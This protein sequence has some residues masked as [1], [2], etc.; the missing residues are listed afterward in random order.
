MENVLRFRPWKGVLA[1][2]EEK[3]GGV[4]QVWPQQSVGHFPE[5]ME[6]SGFSLV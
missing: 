6:S 1:Q 4:T 2:R 5:I 3:W